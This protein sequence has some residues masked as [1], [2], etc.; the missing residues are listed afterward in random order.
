MIRI[1]PLLGILAFGCLTLSMPTGSTAA[2]AREALVIGNATYGALPPM[3]ACLMSVHAIAAALR[4]IGFQVT[5]RED[6]SSGGID[7]AIAEF[8]RQLLAN[9][10]SSAVIYSCGYVTAFNDRPFMLPVSARITRPADV[11]TQGVL[12]K[13][14]I[15]VLAQGGAG[16][17]ILAIDA[18]PMPEGPAKLGLDALSQVNLPDGLG[19]IAVSQSKPPDAPTPLATALIASLRG[20]E[21]QTGP[22]LDAVQQQIS[23]GKQGSLAALRA[24]VAPGFLAGAPPPPPPP[25]APPVQAMLAPV[26][27]PPVAPSAPPVT[28]PADELMTDPDR[29]SV[30]AALV[31][32]G[33]YPGPIDGIF[34][35][36]SRAAIRR[37]QHELGAEMTGRLTA[38]QA[39]RLV[40]GR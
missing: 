6:V 1:Q 21:V 30:Q 11:L 32:L 35:S 3:P 19:L 33:Y 5:E 20:P 23:E 15:D 2:P 9:P 16:A 10:A 4:G 18:V 22:L 38:T 14:L 25:T 26:R 29:R 39:S 7:A 28:M 40:S 17:S 12:A 31:R 36:D 8:A 34:G 24:P 27:P 13:T 37:Y